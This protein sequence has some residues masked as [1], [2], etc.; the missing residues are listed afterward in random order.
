MLSITYVVFFFYTTVILASSN[1][2]ASN[3]QEG[4]GKKFKGRGP[5]QLTGRANYKEAGKALQLDF[6]NHPEKVKTREVGFR[7]SVWFRKK[8]KLN[9]LVD[10]NT[11]ES[12]RMITKRING[13][14]RGQVDREKYWVKAKHAL[15]C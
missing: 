5:I 1:C 8:H 14:S 15:G 3:S 12:F 2:D 11:L 4:D 13:G 9:A 6:I 10:K 7:T